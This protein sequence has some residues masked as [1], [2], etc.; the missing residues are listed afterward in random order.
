MTEPHGLLAGDDGQGIGDADGR[1]PA[2][3]RLVE[4]LGAGEFQR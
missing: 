2:L 3:Q 4:I 1:Q